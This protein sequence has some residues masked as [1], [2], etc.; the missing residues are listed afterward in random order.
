VKEN[1]ARTRDANIQDATIELQHY[2]VYKM[3]KSE[4]QL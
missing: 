4:D 3:G 1:E 2:L